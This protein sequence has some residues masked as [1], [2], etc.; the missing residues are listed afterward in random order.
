MHRKNAFIETWAARV[1]EGRAA[2]RGSGG[3]AQALQSYAEGMQKSFGYE[4]GRLVCIQSAFYAKAVRPQLP[5]PVIAFPE[6]DSPVGAMTLQ[7]IT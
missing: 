6:A 7:N 3:G 2:G 5:H 1:R 4:S